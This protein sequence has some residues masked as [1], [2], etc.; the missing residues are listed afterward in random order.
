MCLAANLFCVQPLVPL[1]GRNLLGRGGVALQSV[2]ARV[3]VSAFEAED[4][5]RV[6]VRLGGTKART[7]LS[8]MKL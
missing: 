3:G 1:D 5:A 7:R 8:T 6:A 2:R 4:R